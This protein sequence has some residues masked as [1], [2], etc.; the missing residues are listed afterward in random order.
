MILLKGGTVVN[1]KTGL[2][3]KKDILIDENRIIKVDDL[4]EADQ[5]VQMIEVNDL[6]IFP[7]FIDL[8]VHLREP[9]FESKETIYTG[10]RACAKGG[11]TS[12]VCMPNTKPALHS[13]EVIKQL[14]SIIEKDSVISIFPAGAITMDIA[15]EVLSNHDQ[16]FESGVVALSDDGR[17]TMNIEYMKKAFTSSRKWNRP[18][19]THSEDHEVTKTLKESIFPT[20]A[21]SDIVE[22]DIALCREMNGILHIS[23][24]ST[25][26]TIEAINNAKIE[27][28]EVT[29]EAAPHHFALSSEK[30]DMSSTLSKVNPP[31]RSEEDRLKV[32]EAI[33]N[34]TIEVIATDHAPHETA[35]K[36]RSYGDASFGISGIESAF[37]VS[38][39]ALVESGEIEL[40]QF[41]EMLTVNPARIARLENLGSIEPGYLANIVV[42]DL[43]Q[44]VVIDS[45]TFISKGKNTPFN[46]YVGKGEVV[47]TIHH[48][49]VVYSK[50]NGRNY[51][52]G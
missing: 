5:D 37:S 30:V 40:D 24:V 4:I 20:T 38:Y 32:I 10:S 13:V 41:I 44:D 15:G 16:L 48:G 50:T 52:I 46:G 17:T 21:E 31:I 22:R 11:Y 45:D 23:H 49:K 2:H 7:G 19:M 51:V 9:G 35:S 43:K 8:H 42:V 14:Q 25:Q 28:V 26:K 36:E 33:K 47:G 18:V 6:Y 27:G 39:K 1:P 29:G 12:V 3:G 34:R